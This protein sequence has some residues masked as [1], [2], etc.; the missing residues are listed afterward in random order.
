MWP[1]PEPAAMPPA[2]V[3]ETTIIGHAIVNAAD[4]VT[5]NG[6]RFLNDN[7]DDLADLSRSRPAAEP[8]A[9][10]SPIRSS[11]RP[12]PEAP[13]GVDDRAISTTVI[14]SGK[15]S[16]TDNLISGTSHGQFGTAS[17]AAASGSTAAGSPRRHRQH[18]R[19]EPHRA[20]P[21]HV[22]HFDRERLEQRAARASAP[23]RPRRRCGRA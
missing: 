19:V 3:G 12:S 23:A 11:G 17:W 6:L 7:V 15:V 13:G 22:R 10:W 18:D 4:N 14:G 2:E 8:P 21:R 9:I 1:A 5:L 20:Q 16:I